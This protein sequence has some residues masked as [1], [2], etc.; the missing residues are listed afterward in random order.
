MHV[1]QS[2][3]PDSCV[4]GIKACDKLFFPNIFTLLKLE[5]TFP[6]TSAECE[7]SASVLMRLIH[8]RRASMTGERLSSLAFIHIHYD[9]NHTL[10][11]IV[12]KCSVIVV[13]HLFL[14]DIYK[15]TRETYYYFNTISKLYSVI[16]LN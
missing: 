6:V 8:Y 16:C 5:C 4:K 10:D 14:Y 15:I 7:R 1:D 12:D 2:E 9:Y 11:D 3:L 13:F